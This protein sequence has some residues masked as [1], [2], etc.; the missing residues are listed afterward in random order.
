VGI[1][2]HVVIALV[3]LMALVEAMQDH[4]TVVDLMVI[5]L[6]PHG[7]LMALEQDLLVVV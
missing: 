7:L 2:P 5:V 6:K 3:V 4:L 1:A